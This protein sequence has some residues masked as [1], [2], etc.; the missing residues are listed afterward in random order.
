MERGNVLFR[1]L[2]ELYSDLLKDL[3]WIST[4][5]LMKILLLD[6]KISRGEMNGLKTVRTEE[7]PNS[8]T[9]A[10]ATA[11]VSKNNSFLLPRSTKKMK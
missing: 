2:T 7:Y 6:F 8:Q 11:S 9:T 1:V 4:M 5:Q 10:L 3:D